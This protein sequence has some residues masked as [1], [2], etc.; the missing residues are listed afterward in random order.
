MVVVVM[1][2]FSGELVVVR[3]LDLILWAVRIHG[4][5]LNKNEIKEIFLKMN[6]FL[7][8]NVG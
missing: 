5:F 6:L 3:G 4:N 1:K 7:D 8:I 2:V